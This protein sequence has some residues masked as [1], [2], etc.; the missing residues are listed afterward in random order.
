MSMLTLLQS[1]SYTILPERTVPYLTYIKRSLV[2]SFRLVFDQH[3]DPILKNSNVT[4][5]NPFTKADYPC[6][7]IRFFERQ[8]RNFGLGHVE[9]LT[10][11]GGVSFQRFKHYYYDGDVEYMIYGLSSY[12]RDLIAD[13]LVQTIAMGDLSGYT[14]NFI[15]RLYYPDPTQY[16]DSLMNYININTDIITGGG[17]TQVPIPWLAEDN[18]VYQRSYRTQAYGEFY[19]IPPVNNI[20]K[21][22]KVIFY[23]Y[24]PGVEAVPNGSNDPAAWV[25]IVTL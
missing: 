13:T 15:N 8:I 10:R 18:F 21:V 3:V 1:G 16:P 25:P 14:S 22:S 6:L 24:I 4:L 17:E 12:D 23:P 19:S 5:D 2:Q 9:Y 11:D 7:V 20:A